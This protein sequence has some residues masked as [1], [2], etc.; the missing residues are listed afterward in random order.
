MNET[1]ELKQV[2]VRLCLKEAEPLY[3]TE[4]ITDSDKAVE[5]MAKALAE[6]DREYVCVVNL[7]ARK[8]PINYSIVSIGDTANCAIPIQ[9]LFKTAILQNSSSLLALHNH[10]SGS[11]E[12]SHADLEVTKRMV[13]AGKLIGIPITDHIIVA[14]ST[15]LHTSIRSTNPEIFEYRQPLG[16]TAEAGEQRVAYRGKPTSKVNEI[17]KKL[18]DGVKQVFDSDKYRTYLDTVAKFHNYSVNNTILIAMQRPDASYVAGYTAWK[19]KFHRNVKHGEKGITIIAPYTYKQTKANNDTEMKEKEE[20]I[21]RQGFKTA[22]VFDITQTE[23]ENLPTLVKELANPVDNYFSLLETIREISPVP[24]RFSQIDSGANGFY[25]HNKREIVIKHGMSEE[26]SI[27]TALHEVAHA[28]LRHGD[29]D[30]KIDRKAMEVQAESVAYC[31]CHALGLDTSEYSFGYVAGWSS[32]KDVKELKES[33]NI[34]RG[35]ASK[36]ITEL[37]NKFSVKIKQEKVKADMPSLSY[38]ASML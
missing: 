34:I 31:C 6:M 32:G 30:I 37:Q 13:E 10:P 1:F 33:L 29:K 38:K 21:L 14:G 16:M 22:T 28:R 35:E 20:E 36:M 9:N 2:A 18:E 17:V 25:S 19:D 11:L 12:P 8:H 26:Q 7:D 4:A 3:S 5:V 24:I 27:K 23:G 15:G